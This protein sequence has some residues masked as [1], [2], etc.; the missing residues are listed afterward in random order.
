MTTG[1]PSPMAIL[2]ARIQRAYPTLAPFTAAVFAADLLR[3]ERELQEAQEDSS[4]RVLLIRFPGET[5]E[6]GL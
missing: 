3:F 1:N 5:C 6:I 2:A 4:T